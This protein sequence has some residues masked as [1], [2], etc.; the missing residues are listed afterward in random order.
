MTIFKRIKQRIAR[1]PLRRPLVWYGHRQVRR[2]DVMVAGY[3]RAGSTW[4]RFLLYGLFSGD[5]ATFPAVNERIPDVGTGS[6]APLLP[7]G[8]RLI[9]THEPYRDIYRR[10]IYMVRDVR[11]VVI[12]EYHFQL[13]T[14][15]F[16]GELT[17]FIPRFLA[18]TVN[19]YGSW[20]D[21]VVSW[22]DSPA[23][24]AGALFVIR[25]EDLKRETGKQLSRIAGFLGADA[26]QARI[27]E[28]VWDNSV[29]RMREKETAAGENAISKSRDDERFIR[30]GR[31]GGW[32]ETLER[33]QVMSLEA[34]C[35]PTLERLGYKIVAAGT[36]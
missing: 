5:S 36:E 30:K 25:F 33:R 23:A 6:P 8:G 27:E 16:A 29:R 31:A 12:S 7:E 1:T 28:V 19:S 15:R 17:E 35:A 26:D 34:M 2:G 18:G 10:G 32:R 24:E 20:R 13:M 21:H 11:D 9:K 4:L 14:G 3:P 22:L